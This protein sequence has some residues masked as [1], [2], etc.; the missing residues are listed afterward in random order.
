MPPIRQL[1]KFFGTSFVGEIL[2]LMAGAALPLAFAPYE[3]AFVAI[4]SL[5]VLFATWL[6]VEPGR[7]SFRGYLF[8]LGQFGFGVSWVFISMHEFS[9]ASVFEAGALTLLFVAFLAVYPALAGFLASRLFSA[10]PSMWR[11]CAGFPATWIGV[12]WLKG[13]F[14]SGFPWLEVGSSQVGSVI[15]Q[16]LIPLAGGYAAGLMSAA[17]AG[18]LVL[19][20][21]AGSRRPRCVALLSIIALLGVCLGLERLQWTEVAGKHFEVSLLQGNIPQNLKWQ[22]EAQR[23]TLDLYVGMTRQH[24]HSDLIVWPETAVPAFYHQVKDTYFAALQKEAEVHGA[25]LL[26]GLPLMNEAT[27]RYYNAIISLGERP[28][29]YFKRHLVPFGE[30]LPLRPVLGFVLNILQIPLSDFSRGDENQPVMTAAGYSLAPSICF[31][32]IFGHESRRSLPQ[33]AYLVNVTNDAWFGDSVAPHQHLQIARLRALETGRSLLRATNTGISAVVS[34]KG[35]ILARGPLFQRAVVTAMVEPRSGATPY[36]RWGDWPVMLGVLTV[37]VTGLRASM[38][39]GAMLREPLI[40][41][42]VPAV[43]GCTAK[44]DRLND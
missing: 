13:W 7:A 25:D 10:V 41:S 31:E 28:G 6:D 16:G 15:G 21:I 32:D 24:W 30:Y 4:L 40:N 19:T 34:H 33:A 42:A 9:G 2:A 26:I 14:L 22:P 38:K 12:E 5:A 20:W 1:P 23:S 18:L 37:L 39:Q 35:Q 44:I 11:L 29:K 3:Y 27:E 43:R 8:G 17:I 36:V